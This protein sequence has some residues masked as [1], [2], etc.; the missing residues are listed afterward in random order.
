MKRINNN[1]FTVYGINS[2]ICVI[3]SGSLDIAS[4]DI[5]KDSRVDKNQSLM[6]KISR[7]SITPQFYKKDSFYQKYPDGRVQG[8]V[9]S[10]YGDVLKKE[11]LVILII[12]LGNRKE[13]KLSDDEV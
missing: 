3:E 10:F 4:I 8:I 6:K 11:P 12:C 7:L 9:V 1:Q 2:A 5:L 13:H